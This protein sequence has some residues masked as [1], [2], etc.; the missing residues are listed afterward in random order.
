MK[1]R[2]E[3]RRRK[4]LALAA[5]PGTPGEKESALQ[6]LE[7]LRAKYGLDIAEAPLADEDLE[8]DIGEISL[9][10]LPF[11]PAD[12]ER[13]LN[14]IVIPPRTAELF[15]EARLTARQIEILTLLYWQE[16][17]EQQIANVMEISQPVVNK[18]KKAG[19]LKLQNKLASEGI[20]P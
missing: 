4:L 14:D 16:M 7:E 3:R 11:G 19:L 8:D 13:L 10:I 12:R 20:K 2:D 15:V 6:R 9:P 17:T 1:L 5:R 18:I